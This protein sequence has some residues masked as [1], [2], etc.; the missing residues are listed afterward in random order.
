MPELVA[1]GDFLVHWESPMVSIEVLADF[2]ALHQPRRGV[3]VIRAALPRLSDRSESY[4]ES[5]LRVLIL[6]AGLPQPEVNYEIRGVRGRVVA[7]VDL[8][9]PDEK[10][11]VE[12]EGD[13]HRTDRVQ[14]QRD[15]RRIEVLQDAGW[16]VVRVSADDLAA[17]E[18][19]FTRL[20]RLL[21]H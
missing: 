5:I 10:V 15:L 2:V 3:S 21:Q 7:R 1:A 8:A 4:R 6:D 16:R 14:W 17:P 20:R 19:L 18:A 13:H 11:A 12:Y 9:W